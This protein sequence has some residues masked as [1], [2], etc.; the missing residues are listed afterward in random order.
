MKRS[1]LVAGIGNIFLRDDGWG[2][3]VA[4]RLAASPPPGA[5]VTDFGISGMHLAYEML[6]GYETVVLVDA[7]SRGGDPGT[8]YLIEPELDDAAGPGDAHRMDLQS[9]FGFMNQIKTGPAPAILVVGCEPADVGEGMGLS[10]TVTHAIEPALAM[11]RDVLV[12]RT[13]PM[14]SAAHPSS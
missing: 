8:V 13:E 9:V 2:S 12:R 14:A 4:R 6:S 10:E 11:I 1:V 7:V 5:T 3:E